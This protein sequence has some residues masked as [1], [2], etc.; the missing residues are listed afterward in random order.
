MFA[1]L[2]PHFKLSVFFGGPFPAPNGEI[3][4]GKPLK[5][6]VG[7]GPHIFTHLLYLFTCFESQMKGNQ[8]WEFKEGGVTFS[9]FFS[10]YP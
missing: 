7:S 4:T 6:A 2:H 3:F 9:G 1:L 8:K 10:A 5:S